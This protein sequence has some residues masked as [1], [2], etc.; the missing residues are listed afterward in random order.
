MSTA[1]DILKLLN[2][3]GSGKT[4]TQSISERGLLV[5]SREEPGNH[6]VCWLMGDGTYFL[7]LFFSS[8]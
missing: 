8:R 4:K 2:L 5:Q 3:T 7:R 6:T 1:V